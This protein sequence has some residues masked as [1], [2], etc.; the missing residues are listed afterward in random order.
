MAPNPTP[1]P[2]RDTLPDD[3]PAAPPPDD[4]YWRWLRENYTE[5]Q[6]E[7]MLRAVDWTE[8]PPD[9]R[10]GYEWSR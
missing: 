2:Y 7:W 9:S 4:A 5:A 1:A 10:D 6:I 8:T 3:R